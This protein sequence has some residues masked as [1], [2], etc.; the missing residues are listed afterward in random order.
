MAGGTGSCS[1]SCIWTYSESAWAGAINCG[2]GCTCNPPTFSG[3]EGQTVTTPCVSSSS[4]TGNC[5]WQ[6]IEI[7]PG[8]YNWDNYLNTCTS[9]PGCDCKTP[10][11]NP[12]LFPNSVLTIACGENPPA[13][14]PGEGWTPYPSDPPT[15]TPNPSETPEGTPAATD[16]PLP[17]IQPCIID[18]ACDS[19]KLWLWGQ[20][21]QGQLGDGTTVHKSSPVQ[22][23]DSDYEWCNSSVGGKHVGA[24]RSDGSLYLWGYN[25]YG[26][27][28]DGSSSNKSYLSSN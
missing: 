22:V 23:L 4:C 2:S 1:G 18:F 28:G 16:V 6:S 3:Y 7:S 17:T 20:N 9:D 19:G 5:Y 13:P 11:S 24:I 14:F 26:Q 21:D 12:N 8:F 10:L 15:P 25:T 27:L